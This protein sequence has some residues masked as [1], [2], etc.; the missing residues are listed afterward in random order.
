MM[1][2]AWNTSRSYT[3]SAPPSGGLLACAQEVPTSSGIYRESRLEG[4]P[5]HPRYASRYLVLYRGQWFAISDNTLQAARAFIDRLLFAPSAPPS[6]RAGGG[7][8]STKAL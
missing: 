1:T 6:E 4:D 2:A 3:F 8:F 5:R 7:A